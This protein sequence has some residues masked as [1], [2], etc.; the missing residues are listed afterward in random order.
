[1][2]RPKKSYGLYND[3]ELREEIL[4]IPPDK[5]NKELNELRHQFKSHA[6]VLSD[7]VRSRVITLLQRRD[8]NI[9]KAQEMTKPKGGR[10]G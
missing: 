5:C 9:R 7:K 8:R 1:M 6:S 10:R 2:P 4:N 3:T